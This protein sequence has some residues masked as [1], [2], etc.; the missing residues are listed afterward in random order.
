[1]SIQEPPSHGGANEM[2]QV[3][4]IDDISHLIRAVERMPLLLL[5]GIVLAASYILRDL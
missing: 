1:M 4:V 5:M 3:T 2:A